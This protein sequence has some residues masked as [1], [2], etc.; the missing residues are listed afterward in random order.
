[1]GKRKK[2]SVAAA[3]APTAEE[4]TKRSKGDDGAHAKARAVAIKMLGTSLATADDIDAPT[5]RGS[6]E[7]EP[8]AVAE[9]IERA[10]FEARKHQVDD[11]YKARLRSLAF[12][13]RNVKNWALRRSVRA[14]K[15]AP[16]AFVAMRVPELADPEMA[17][18]RRGDAEWAKTV[19]M[20]RALNLSA[21]TRAYTCRRCGKN[22]CRA[23]QLQ[24]RGA[25]EGM[26]TFVSCVSCGHRWR[27]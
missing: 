1:M 10:L 19:A 2:A 6:Y 24:I 13:L 5:D 8:H 27:D 25:D 26:T 14:G 4:S 3:A 15:I 22:E 11:A 17:A 21:P 16:R 23:A 12:N 20:A 7:T 9:E 18:A